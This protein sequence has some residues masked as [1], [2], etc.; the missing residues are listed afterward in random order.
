MKAMTRLFPRW[1]NKAYARANG[2][3]WLHC[4]VC[5]RESGGHEWEGESYVTSEPCVSTIP[6]YLGNRDI[7]NSTL[8]QTGKGV[9]PWCAPAVRRIEA[10]GEIVTFQ[11]VCRET[12]FGGWD[13]A[14]P[15]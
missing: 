12:G 10:R 15:V 5:D 8:M 2:Y 14:C 13:A 4:D 1:V 7:T 9:C 11:A 6:V 3:F